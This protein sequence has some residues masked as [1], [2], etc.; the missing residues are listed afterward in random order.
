LFYLF[1]FI[2]SIAVFGNASTSNLQFPTVELA[3]RVN[4]PGGIFERIDAFVFSIWI[5]AIFNTIS[6]TLDLTIHFI[7]SI[8]KKARRKMTA[9]ILAPILFY[10]SMF[11]RTSDQIDQIVSLLNWLTIPVH[12]AV[13]L[14]LFIVLKVRGANV[15]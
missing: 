15:L 11:P 8:V 13:I 2:A 14:V 9:F 5:M 4:I 3:K 10:L 7:C 6:I 1:I 12:C